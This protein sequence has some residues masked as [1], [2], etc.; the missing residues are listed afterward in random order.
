MSAELNKKKAI[1]LKARKKGVAVGAFNFSE[2]SQLKGIIAAGKKTGQPFI[3]QT[4]E[5]ESRYLGLDYSY[6]LKT[7]AEKELGCPLIIN[8]DHGKSFEYIKGAVDAGYEMVHFDGSKLPLDE[9][10]KIAKKV[11]AYAHKKGV[12]VEG[13]VGYL[14]GSS[15]IH[16]E[17]LKIRPE[18]MTHPE[19]AKGFIEKTGVD[20]LAI[21]IGN[22]HGVCAQMPKLDIKR[23]SAIHK[24]LRGRAF[25][26][27]HG[28]SGI[29]AGQIRKAISEGITKINVNT[30]LRFAWRSA[31]E[32]SMKI[33]AGEVAPPIIMPLAVEEVRKAVEAKMAMFGGK[34]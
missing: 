27:L 7:A 32:K 5:A 4:S 15:K 8:Q 3:V 24:E 1:F 30:E 34:K 26:T 29:P 12:I 25:L 19:E 33:N 10:I 28:G 9:N 20:L 11:V 22:V 21:A 18:D 31:V 6:A 14:G 17:A 2:V 16:K 13:E 23:L